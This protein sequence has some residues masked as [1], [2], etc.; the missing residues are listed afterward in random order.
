MQIRADKS[1][2][3]Y[4]DI[5]SDGEITAGHGLTINTKGDAQTGER[6]VLTFKKP[7]FKF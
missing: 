2:N 1:M 7:K 4:G 5:T 6:V 3:I